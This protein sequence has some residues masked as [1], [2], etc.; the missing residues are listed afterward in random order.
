MSSSRAQRVQRRGTK[1]ERKGFS[2]AWIRKESVSAEKGRHEKIP[3]G[4]A[5]PLASPSP[6]SGLLPAQLCP[7]PF[8][9]HTAP[10]RPSSRFKR[11][12]CPHCLKLT[13]RACPSSLPFLGQTVALVCTP[14]AL[15]MDCEQLF[16]QV[17]PE[18]GH[19]DCAH[20][21][22]RLPAERASLEVGRRAGAGVG[23]GLGPTLLGLLCLL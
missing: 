19:R 10:S 8:L 4:R 15:K 23:H 5:W 16:T 21:R 14:L 1:L 17:W 18:P 6:F 12:P 3:A 2:S 11:V 7:E 9:E 20:V 13:A 22:A